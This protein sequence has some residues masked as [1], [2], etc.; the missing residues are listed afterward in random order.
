MCSHLRRGHQYLLTKQWN[1]GRAIFR[2]DPQTSI[3]DG[4]ENTNEIKDNNR[5]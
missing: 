3:R 2:K 4:P 5:E 1:Q